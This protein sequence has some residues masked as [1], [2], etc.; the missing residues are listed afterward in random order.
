[1]PIGTHRF[2]CFTPADQAKIWAALTDGQETGRYLHGLFAHSSWLA[3]API[4]FRTTL[5][6]AAGHTL[7]TG[8]V[9]HVQPFCRLSYLL[10]SGPKDPPV[11][12]TWQIRSC[13]GGSTVQLQIDEVE[14]ADTDEEAENTWLPVL[15]ALQN[16]L[17]Q[18]ETAPP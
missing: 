18:D 17:A 5:S 3:D 2:R 8:R 14:F 11:Y 16:L 12:L 1:M 13:P 9:L 7:L 15:A 4:H 10:Q 6:Q